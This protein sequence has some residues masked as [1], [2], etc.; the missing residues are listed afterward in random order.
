LALFLYQGISSSPVSP[1]NEVQA[2]GDPYIGSSF[3]KRGQFS[4]HSF[5]VSFF[6]LGQFLPGFHGRFVPSISKYHPMQ[7]YS[8]W[9]TMDNYVND[10]RKDI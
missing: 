1:E 4:C 9:A 8:C 2:S 3:R 6:Q 10:T 7:R 5:V